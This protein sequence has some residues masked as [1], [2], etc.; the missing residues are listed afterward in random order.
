[1]GT[2]AKRAEDLAHVV[3]R[4][5]VRVRRAH[6]H[7]LEQV[8]GAELCLDTVIVGIAGVVAGKNDSFVAIHTAHGISVIRLRCGAGSEA[9][10]YKLWEL[11]C[12]V[13]NEG[14]GIHGLEQLASVIAHVANFKCRIL[15]EFAFD[16][17]A[18]TLNLIGSEVR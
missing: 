9:R 12:Q 4:L 16:S 5:A 15:C 7:L 3:Q 1:S 6:A 11:S 8:I 10:W 14:V 17:Q 13:S 18:P 2:A